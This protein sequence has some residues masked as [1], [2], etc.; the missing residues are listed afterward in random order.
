MDKTA[1]TLPA[2]EHYDAAYFA[3]QKDMG[4]FGGRVNLT[5]FES[6]IKPTEKVLEFGCGG[7]FL[8]SHI[9][10]AQKIGIE[11]NDAARAHASTLGIHTVPDANEVPDAWA[12]VIISDNALE[13]VAC[14]YSIMASLYTK[15]RPGGMVVFVIPCDAVTFAYKEK[16]I[17]QHFFSWSPMNIGNMLHN[18]GFNIIEAKPYLHKWPPHYARIHKYLGR[19]AFELCARVYGWFKRDWAQVRV[20][21]ARPEA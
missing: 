15:L 17:N 18:I 12:D 21:A 5:K 16:D 14:P 1:N 11:V 6:Y 2:S 8:L 20:V 10:C 13:H 19:T 7:G 3:W 9:Q 4:E